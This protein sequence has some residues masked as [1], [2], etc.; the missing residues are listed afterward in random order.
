LFATFIRQGI[1]IIEGIIIR[2]LAESSRSIS[3]SLWYGWSNN[4]VGNL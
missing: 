1:L 2:S 3:C 4:F